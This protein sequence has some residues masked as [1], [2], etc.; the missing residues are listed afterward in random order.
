MA[1]PPTL[2]AELDSFLYPGNGFLD[3]LLGIV[4]FANGMLV[5]LM[6]SVVRYILV[7]M[8]LSTVVNVTAGGRGTMVGCPSYLS[9]LVVV[10]SGSDVVAG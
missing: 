8:S 5:S 10:V 2:E 3:L 1:L 9:A 4:L 6:T 7:G